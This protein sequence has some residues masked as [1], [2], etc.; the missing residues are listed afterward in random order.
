LLNANRK[1]QTLRLVV[2]YTKLFVLWGST[3][4]QK[5]L[6]EPCNE[7]TRLKKEANKLWIYLDK[8][9]YTSSPSDAC[10]KDFKQD[11]A[12]QTKRGLD[13]FCHIGNLFDR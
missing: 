8:F 6:I 7:N 11:E 4:Q 1:S 12:D 10:E 2:K 13:S 9:S 3:H 5:K